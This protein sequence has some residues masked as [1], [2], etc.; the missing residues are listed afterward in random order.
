MG[1][2]QL[3]ADLAQSFLS[4]QLDNAVGRAAV[5]EQYQTTAGQWLLARCDLSLFRD[6][7]ISLSLRLRLFRD[8]FMDFS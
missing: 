2:V 3:A 5:A 1:L 7:F 6:F 8:F 4:S